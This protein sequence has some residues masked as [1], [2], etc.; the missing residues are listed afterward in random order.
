MCLQLAAS[1]TGSVQNYSLSLYDGAP[2]NNILLYQATGITT[3][4]YTDILAPQSGTIVAEIANTDADATNVTVT[5]RIWVWYH[6]MDCLH[7]SSC[8]QYRSLDH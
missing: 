3:R 5:S 8:C 7:Q 4:V 2:G 6:R 1:T